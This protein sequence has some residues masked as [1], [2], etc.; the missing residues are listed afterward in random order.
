MLDDNNIST[1]KNNVKECNEIFYHLKS[2]LGPYGRD[3]LI[4]DK[5]NNYLSTNDGAT[6]LKY[7][8]IKHPA[9]RLLIGVAKSQDETVGDGTTSVVLLTCLLLQNSLKYILLSIHPIIFIKGFQ[10]SL[11]FCLKVIDEIKVSPIQNISDLGNEKVFDNQEYLNHLNSIASTSISSKILARFSSHFSNLGVEAIKKLRFNPVQDLVRVIGITGNSM[12]ES[13]LIDGVLLE[14]NNEQLIHYRN[15]QQNNGDQFSNQ[16]QLVLNK[17]KIIIGKLQ[18]N[19][20]SSTLQN[21]SISADASIIQELETR[22]ILTKFDLIFKLGINIVISDT[23]LPPLVEQ[24]FKDKG[25]LYFNIQD[26]RELETLSYCLNSKLIYDISQIE[27]SKCTSP[28]KPIEIQSIGDKIFLQVSGVSINSNGATM[29]LRSPTDSMLQ[30]CIRSFKDMLNILSSSVR[31]P[32][33]VGGGG[34]IYVEFAKRLREK[35]TQIIKDEKILIAIN[36]FAD[37]LEMI[38]MIL[39]ENAGYEP[40]ELIGKLKS[41]HSQS[42]KENQWFGIDLNDGEIVDMFKSNVR[43][44]SFLISNIL[45]LSSRAAQMILRINNNILIEPRSQ[46]QIINN[47]PQDN[48]YK[49]EEF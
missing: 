47:S 10:I 5:N 19:D 49:E 32:Y 22:E 17:P 15:E 20:I 25:I 11:D 41:Q 24:L 31:N 38:P 1:V 30:E 12:L 21:L 40:I 45:T 39:I 3:K 18:L 7:L 43:E 37:S 35:A 13:K 44:P 4:L 14:I 16:F 23:L 34:S 6:I 29:V 28:S 33:L 9:A 27:E 26:S 42:G 36:C 2:T 48:S 8:K 46:Y